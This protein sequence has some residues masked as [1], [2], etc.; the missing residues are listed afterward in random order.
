MRVLGGIFS[1]LPIRIAHNCRKITDQFSRS[2]LPNPDKELIAGLGIG[3]PGP[4]SISCRRSGFAF[5]LLRFLEF[6]SDNVTVLNGVVIRL[7]GRVPNSFDIG[8]ESLNVEISR[9]SGGESAFEGDEHMQ[10]FSSVSVVF[11][12]ND[13]FS[14][15]RLHQSQDGSMQGPTRSL[16]FWDI[17]MVLIDLRVC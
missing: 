4:V 16:L 11:S 10:V 5:S 15:N 1:V 17:L 2:A 6:A 13:A 3:D 7:P 12:A 14:L 8:V 9:I